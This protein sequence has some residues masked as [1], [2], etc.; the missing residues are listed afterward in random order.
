MART[1]DSASIVAGVLLAAFG[2]VLLLDAAGDI[3]LRFAALG[4]I[5]LLLV[6]APLLASG[7]T[8]RG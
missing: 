1:R 6:G 7:L 3:D 8:R 2:V 4:P 5:A